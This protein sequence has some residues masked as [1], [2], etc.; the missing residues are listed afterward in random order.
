MSQV[1]TGGRSGH[2]VFVCALIVGAVLL[3]TGLAKAAEVGEDP[4]F[5]SSGLED[6][7]PRD[8]VTPGVGTRNDDFTAEELDALGLPQDTP[9]SVAEIVA[10]VRHLDVRDRATLKTEFPQLAPLIEPHPPADTLWELEPAARRLGPKFNGEAV[11][12]FDERASAERDAAE[13]MIQTR[14]AVIPTLIEEALNNLPRSAFATPDTLAAALKSEI[15]PVAKLEQDSKAPRFEFE[16]GSGKLKF[17]GSKDL[18]PARISLGE[19][20]VYPLITKLVALLGAT[21][22][23]VTQDC[24]QQV[25]QRLLAALRNDPDIRSNIRDGSNANV[26]NADEIWRQL[27]RQDPKCYA[28]ARAAEQ[29]NRAGLPP[30]EQGAEEQIEEEFEDP[31]CP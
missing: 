4:T 31:V 21:A 8:S 11:R 2:R 22:C 6:V 15:G 3:P 29:V 20:S 23:T 1:T 17:N 24:M 30:G 27:I 26:V 12:L 5:F 14:V 28:A 7:V 19:V 25:K 10:I 9:G 18:G 13:T 16:L